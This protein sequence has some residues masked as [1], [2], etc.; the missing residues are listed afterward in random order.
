M[1]STVSQFSMD[2]FAFGLKL[3]HCNKRRVI[4]E[5]IKKWN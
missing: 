2:E 1:Y 3:N 5:H 4:K